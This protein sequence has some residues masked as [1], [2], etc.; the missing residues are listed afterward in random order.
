MVYDVPPT[1]VHPIFPHGN[2]VR[3]VYVH[4]KKLPFGLLQRLMDIINE[5]E[6]ILLSLDL[7][8]QFDQW[9]EISLYEPPWVPVWDWYP[10][11]L[12]VVDWVILVFYSFLPWLLITGITVWLSIWPKIRHCFILPLVISCI[13]LLGMSSYYSKTSSH[14]V[15]CHWSWHGGEYSFWPIYM[16]MDQNGGLHWTYW[17]LT[18]K[19][20]STD[21]MRLV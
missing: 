6:L 10:L 4:M 13:F 15:V 11:I 9:S 14:K 16:L 12:I 17:T 5:S 8:F 19:A 1:E 18:K 2:R 3:L 20:R 7:N 21:N